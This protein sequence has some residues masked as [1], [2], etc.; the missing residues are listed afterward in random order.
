[1]PFYFD[2]S[3]HPRGDFILGAYVFGP[4]PTDAIN[5]ALATVGLDPD[6][7]EFKSS[8][9]MAEHPEQQAL[10][11][12]LQNILQHT[13]RFGLVV[14]P[15][16]ERAS[17]GRH[18]LLGLDKVCQA[19]D[20]AHLHERAYF[21][22]GIFSSSR[23]ATELA[24]QI[25]VSQY[26]E[27]HPEQDSRLAKGV[28][29]ADLVAH[30]C[31]L[32]LLDALGLMSKVVKAGPNSGYD[33]DLDIELGFELWASVRY[34]F[35]NGGLH[36]HIDSNEDMVVDVATYGL[37]IAQSCSPRLRDAALE[38]FGTQYWGCIH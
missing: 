15:H 24:Q 23:A 32:M 22:Q 20:L 27:V 21:D 17:L 31:A 4:D 25:G 18:A 33:P 16:H 14:V 6:R 38:R 9:K 37:H 3:I 7:D 10:R 8:A 11:R 1:M 26:C 5:A 29:L 36:D 34:Q 13:Y 2:E 12:E 28:Q 19:N 35:F 30:T